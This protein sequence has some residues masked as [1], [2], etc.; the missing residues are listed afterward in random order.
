MRSEALLTPATVIDGAHECPAR[1]RGDRTTRGVNPAGQVMSIRP[2]PR[3]EAF[4]GRETAAAPERTLLPVHG[5][6]GERP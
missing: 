2:W 5:L 4:T 1:T 6:S 3:Q